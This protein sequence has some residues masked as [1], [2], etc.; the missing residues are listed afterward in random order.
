MLTKT[1]DA[2][3]VLLSNSS[4]GK[5]GLVGSMMDKNAIDS[6]LLRSVYLL[7]FLFLCTMYDI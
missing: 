6:S 5:A 2:V 1:K 4:I 7:L 3:T